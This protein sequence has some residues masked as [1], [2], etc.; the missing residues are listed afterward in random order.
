MT[1]ARKTT[2]RKRPSVRRAPARR[3]EPPTPLEQLWL[4]GLGALA[5]T[6]EAASST[7]ETLIARGRKREPQAIRAVDRAVRQARGRV[8]KLANAAG[9]RTKEFLDDAIEQLGVREQPRSKNILHRLG[10]LAEA[11]L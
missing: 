1:Q 2:N 10:D 3:P 9:R 6:G 4:A 11:L 7:V 5:A 8:E